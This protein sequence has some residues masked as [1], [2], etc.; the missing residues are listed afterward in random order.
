LLRAFHA[1]FTKKK[2][3]GASPSPLSRY[4][5]MAFLAHARDLRNLLTVAEK[6]RLLAD[7]TRCQ[8][9]KVLYLMAAEALEKR[10]G[11]LE[12]TLPEEHNYSDEKPRP[13]QPVNMII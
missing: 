4:L 12:G 5:R 8:G 11:W 9:D 1:S 2:T 10:A 6:L 7:D 3:F 13:H